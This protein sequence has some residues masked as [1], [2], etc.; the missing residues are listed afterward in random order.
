MPI[1][2][3]KERAT[4]EDKMYNHKRFIYFS[5]WLSSI[6][7]IKHR[8]ENYKIYDIMFLRKLKIRVTICLF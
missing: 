4:L 6:K 3:T 7:L 1:Y 5:F 2:P 8:E